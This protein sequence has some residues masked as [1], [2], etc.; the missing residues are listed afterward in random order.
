MKYLL[1]QNEYDELRM[2][3]AELDSAEI[4]NRMLVETNEKL[5]DSINRKGL[6]DDVLVKF[7]FPFAQAV[8][9]AFKN[10]HKSCVDY[11]R[12]SHCLTC[13]IIVDLQFHVDQHIERV[14]RNYTEPE[15]QGDGE[16]GAVRC[17]KCD[18]T[19]N[20]DTFRL[21]C[22]EH[23]A[24]VEA[25]QTSGAPDGFG[26]MKAPF[27]QDF[28]TIET[29]TEYLP[30]LHQRSTVGFSTLCGLSLHNLPEGLLASDSTQVTCSACYT[31][32]VREFPKKDESIK[33]VI[34]E[35]TEQVFNL[36]MKTAMENGAVDLP[37][38]LPDSVFICQTCNFIS[39]D[40]EQ[41]FV[42]FNKRWHDRCT[43]QAVVRHELENRDFEKATFR[44][45]FML[46]ATAQTNKYDFPT[47]TEPQDGLPDCMDCDYEKDKTGDRNALCASHTDHIKPSGAPD[48]SE[49]ELICPYDERDVGQ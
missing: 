12:P 43:T 27:I 35:N 7:T 21:L 45:G 32:M 48:V 19:D 16:Y 14:R 20:I 26:D 23:L 39:K 9:E 22:P 28:T 24:E 40:G 29:V 33:H 8:L 49:P 41:T 25:W 46:F 1:D 5:C 37:T 34:V 3:K 2:A 36:T 38:D 31:A 4:C 42:M 11:P 6:A 30:I 47:E 17:R 44:E 15:R 13:K 10:S 18:R